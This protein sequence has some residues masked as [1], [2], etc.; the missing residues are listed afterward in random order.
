MST[1]PVALGPP[2]NLAEVIERIA[3]MD[4]LPRQRRLDLMSAVRQVARLLGGLPVDV[5]ANPEALRRALSLLT[6]AAADMTPSR[7]A[8]RS[9]AADGR[10][11]PDRREGRAP[12]TH[13]SAWTPSWLAL[14]K[15]V[16]DRYERARL[17]R[18][19]SYASANGIEPDQVD[20]QIVADFAE[21]L[22]R[23]SLLERQTQIV[24]DLCL[25]WNRCA[26]EH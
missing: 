10:A 12:K 26:E 5:P 21:N 15:R 4:G 20:D 13:A 17:S 9:G 18:F 14:L 3:A 23:N 24:R 19:F 8:K 2:A 22:K 16:G 25:A 7:L 6:P 11:R 1:K